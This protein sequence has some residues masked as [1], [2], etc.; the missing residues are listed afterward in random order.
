MVSIKTINGNLHKYLKNDMQDFFEE[1]EKNFGAD[2]F[3]Q[4]Q[5]IL[6]MSVSG[7]EPKPENKNVFE[8]LVEIYNH[9]P[10]YKEIVDKTLVHLEKVYKNETIDLGTKTANGLTYFR[11]V[12][13]QLEGGNFDFSKLGKAKENNFTL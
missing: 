2:I 3:E 12:K 9:V 5:C 7:K 11:D 1:Y 13:T 10:E 6:F 8:Q 4:T